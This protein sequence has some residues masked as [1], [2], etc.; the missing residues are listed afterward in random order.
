MFANYETLCMSLLLSLLSGTGVFL[1]GVR[2]QR[3]PASIFNLISEWV[4]AL[5]AGFVGFYIAKHK[6]WDDYLLYIVVLISANNSR[7]VTET[8]KT[9]FISILQAVMGGGKNGGT[10]G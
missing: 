6:G 9:K 8:V 2:D 7:E 1:H 3:I 10:N 5:I 4:F